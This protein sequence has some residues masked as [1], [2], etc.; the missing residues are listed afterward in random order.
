[1]GTYTNITRLFH[2]VNWQKKRLHI[3][4]KMITHS[5]AGIWQRIHS[6]ASQ[7]IAYEKSNKYKEVPQMSHLPLIM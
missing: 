5:L 3:R 4:G 1:M 6:M 2:F 7:L